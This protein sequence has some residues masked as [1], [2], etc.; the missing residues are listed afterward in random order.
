MVAKTQLKTAGGLVIHVESLEFCTSSAIIRNGAL[1]SVSIA[2]VTGFPLKA[3]SAGAD[4]TLAVVGDEANVT[5]L[6]MKGPVPLA[7]ATVANSAREYQVLK[8]PPAIINQD[9]I[10]KK[11]GAGASFNI[12]TIVTALKALKFEVRTEPVKM[13]T[14]ST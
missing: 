13:T 4:F 12:A 14:Q 3:G 6:I 5:G 11:D 9:A 8:N 7:L 2:D 10:A 1:T